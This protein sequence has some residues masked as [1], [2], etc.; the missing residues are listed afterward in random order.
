[1]FYFFIYTTILILLNSLKS[2]KNFSKIQRI[3]N[4]LK[5]YKFKSHGNLMI[6]NEGTKD[7]FVVIN[8]WNFRLP[9]NQNIHF[10]IWALVDLHRLYWL[11][12]FND[13]FTKDKTYSGSH[14]LFF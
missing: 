2:I 9:E 1:M 14:I 13:Y 12:K 10:D 8:D 3:Y 6:A 7:E 11:L 4:N 5:F